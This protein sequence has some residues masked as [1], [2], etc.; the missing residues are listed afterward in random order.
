MAAAPAIPAKEKPHSTFECGLYFFWN[1][2]LNAGSGIP[3]CSA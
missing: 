2:P 1:A 3:E